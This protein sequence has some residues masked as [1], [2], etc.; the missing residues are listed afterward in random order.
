MPKSVPWYGCERAPTT[1]R[2]TQGMK[3]SLEYAY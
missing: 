2:T 3:G 1:H